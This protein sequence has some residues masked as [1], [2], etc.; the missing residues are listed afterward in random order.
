MTAAEHLAEAE[1][2]LGKTSERGQVWDEGELLVV[3]L[4]AQTHA[5]IA[6]GIELGV[7]HP[8]VAGG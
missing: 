4:A 2:L 8:A 6:V 1:R 5:V 3:V 7:P